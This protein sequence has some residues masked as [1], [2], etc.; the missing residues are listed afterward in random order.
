MK[1]LVTGGA[2]FIGSNFVRYMSDAGVG[3]IYVLDSLTYAASKEALESI[4]FPSVRVIHGSINN[5]KLLQ[6][7]LEEVDTVV[8]FAAETHNDNSLETPEKFVQTNVLGTFEVLE[9]V[10][11]SGKRLHH[12]S[13]DEV[14]GDL[15]LGSD[16]MFSEDSPYRPSS[17]YSASK[18]A[19]DHLVRAWVKSFGIRATISNCS[20]N[21]G[22]WQ[23]V[24]KFIPRQITEL[25]AGKK[26]KVY[27]SGKHV[28]DWIHVDDHSS[29]VA[30]VL[31]LGVSGETYL[32]GANGEKTNL[33]VVT[34]LLEIFGL[35]SD[36]I[37]FIRDRPGH[38]LR[39][40]VDSTKIKSELGWKPQN[41]DF[42]EK[43]NETVQWY[44]ANSSWWE[45]QKQLTEAR[46]FAKESAS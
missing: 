17:P 7:L 43:L 13:T 36:H 26:P 24:E 35:P 46:Y 44:L 29:A 42:N 12:I 4:R 8:N 14:F 15:P 9:A 25:L 19:S 34:T 28:R 22:P 10:R 40:S 1:L 3:D 45:S 6:E 5:S 23:H 32:I 30:R 39:Y 38:D 16:E 27:G 2:G 20:N 33:E 21:F 41:V 11:R 18:A 31:E 37:E